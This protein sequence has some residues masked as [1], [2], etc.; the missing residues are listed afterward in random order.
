MRVF[1]ERVDPMVAALAQ[2]SIEIVNV[3]AGYY[4][5]RLLLFLKDNMAI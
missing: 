4:Y 1:L 5:I 2:E 3:H